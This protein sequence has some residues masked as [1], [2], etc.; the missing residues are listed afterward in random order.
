MRVVEAINRSLHDLMEAD[1]DLI[2]LGEDVIDPYGG[3]F[4]A[5]QGLSTLHPE[6]VW[7]M[8]IS[9]GAI[10]GVA[11]GLAI[12]GKAAIAELMFGDFI[13]LAA[14]QLINHAAKFQWMYNEQVRCPVI[15]RTPMGGGRGYGPTHSQCLEKHFCGVPGLTVLAMNEYGDPAA[16][17]RR[18]H[19]ARSPHLVIENKTMYARPLLGPAELPRPIDADVAIIAYGGTVSLAVAA[20]KRLMEREEISAAVVPIEQ[21]H[22]FDA[23][24]L[25]LA[26][27]RCERVLVVEEGTEGWGFGATCAV[28]VIGQVRHFRSLSSPDHPV[29]SSRAWEEGVLPNVDAIVAAAVD[30][31][32]TR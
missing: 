13:A 10:V 3:A 5:T 6:R 28:A 26:I 31:F 2:L 11:T 25:R 14:D 17:Y 7:S 23:E 22:P 21:L 32:E 9:E 4:K 16:L 8:P 15:V 24:A 20:A 1:P 30:L 18:A 29:P 27:G 12:E 19:K